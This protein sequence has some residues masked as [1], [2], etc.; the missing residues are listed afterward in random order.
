M[1]RRVFWFLLAAVLVILP[2]CCGAEKAVDAGTFSV[3]EILLERDGSKIW[4][5]LYLPEGDAPLPL[6]I[7]CHGFGGNHEHVK[8]YAEAFARNG[9]AAFAFDFVGGGF[10]SR[11]DGTMKEMSVLTEAADL[12]AVMDRMKEMP[13]I[14]PE[15]IFLL[16]ASQGGFVSSYVAGIRPDDVAGV[17]A[18]YPAYVLQDN[19]WKQTPDPE[20]IPETISLMGVTLGGIY[21]RD[22]QS[23]DIYDV[24]KDYPGKVLILHGTVDS[25]AP[26]S[27]SERAV[28]T[29][30]DAE[31]IRYEGSNHGFMGQDL[32][33]SEN[34]SIAFV[35]EILNASH[36][37]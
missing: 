24:M 4:G 11:S 23:F 32:I 36:G 3:K 8:P 9:I 21:N 35:Q 7:C 27:Y 19:A 31:L 1:L 22:A 34:E 33:R 30:P 28:E 25:I 26:I 15:Q 10:G 17:I 37:E 29:F 12:C 5:K 16:G 6:V 20:A 2:A 13:Q 14:N 18:L